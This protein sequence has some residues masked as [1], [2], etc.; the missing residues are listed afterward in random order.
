MRE[1]EGER[2]GEEGEGGREREGERGEGERLTF[3]VGLGTE[4]TDHSWLWSCGG[5]RQRRCNEASPTLPHPTAALALQAPPDVGC[6][7]KHTH[8]YMH[9]I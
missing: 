9:C 2:G 1:R 3:P 8:L 5:P 4:R 7:H 6:V